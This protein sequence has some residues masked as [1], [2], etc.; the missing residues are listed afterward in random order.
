MYLF[1]PWDRG[2]F[3]LSHHDVSACILLQIQR[4]AGAYTAIPFYILINVYDRIIVPHLA[5]STHG[6]T[7]LRLLEM[8]IHQF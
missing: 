3:T 1:P 4:N 7:D 8:I 2:T 6:V 5:D